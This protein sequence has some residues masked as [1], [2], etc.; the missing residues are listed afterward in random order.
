MSDE[1]EVI[2]PEAHKQLLQSIGNLVRTQHIRKST[3]N[4]PRLHQDEFQLHKDADVISNTTAAS[5]NHSGRL[6]DSVAVNDVVQ[7]LQSSEKHL[8]AGKQLKLAATKKKTLKRPLEKPI[9]QH[10]KR[11]IGYENTKKKLARWDAIV[12]KNRCAEQQVFIIFVFFVF[13]F[14]SYKEVTI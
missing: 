3:R 2:N 5:A 11:T 4:E 12:A 14:F 1:E 7:L 8:D 13:V 10:I 9:A 6:G